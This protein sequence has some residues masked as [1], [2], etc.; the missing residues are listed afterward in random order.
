MEVGIFCS[1]M[2]SLFDKEKKLIDYCQ[3]FCHHQEWV[4]V[5]MLLKK[6]KLLTFVSGFLLNCRKQ[7]YS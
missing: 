1:Q 5:I 7:C 3:C 4:C 2:F 6:N